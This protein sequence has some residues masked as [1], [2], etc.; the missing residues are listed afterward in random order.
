MR[1]VKGVLS[2]AIAAAKQPGFRG[3]LVPAE[4]AQEAAVVEGLD[5]IPIGSLNEAVAFL[6]GKLQ[7]EPVPSRLNEIYEA[8]S[9]YEVDFSDVRGQ[10][11][12]KRAM[13]IAAAGAHNLIMLESVP[14][15]L[16]VSEGTNGW[17]KSSGPFL[18]DQASPDVPNQ[19]KQLECN[20]PVEPHPF[21]SLA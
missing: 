4:N 7:I 17:V 3:L 8:Y 20:S 9:K 5:I 19:F 12:S 18:A 15:C 11:M 13:T 21:W 16:A 1:N 2:I 10:E 6:S 14:S